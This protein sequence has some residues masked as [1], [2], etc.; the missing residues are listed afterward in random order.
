MGGIVT[1]TYEESLWSVPILTFHYQA[2]GLPDL[3]ADDYLTRPDPLSPALSALMR[4]PGTRRVLRRL[5][6]IGQKGI[7]Q[8]NEARQALLLAVIEKYLPLTP[9]EQA[10]FDQLLGDPLNQEE[11]RAML[12]YEKRGYDRGIEQGI[13][14]GVVQGL[15]RTLL[16][17]LRARFGD[18]P[19]AVVA[20]VEA[21]TNADKLDTLSERVLTAPTLD[22]M[23]LL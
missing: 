18:L 6:T 4:S 7:L 22:A 11:Q 16:K 9:D 5:K 3:K 1:E 13:E 23:G 14:R 20:R 19:Q 12:T 2:V 21:I 10:E 15:R 8:E 17:Q